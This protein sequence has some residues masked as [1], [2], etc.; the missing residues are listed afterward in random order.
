MKLKLTYVNRVERTSKAGKPFT[1]LS[2]KAEE[3]N[4][5]YLSGFGNKANESWKVGDVVEVDKVVE[6]VK[7]G[8]TYLNFEIAKPEDKVAKYFE[9]I[10]GKL[11]RQ[12]L[13]LEELVA[14]K[15]LQTGEEKPKIAGTNIDY[16]MPEDEG[17]NLEDEEIKY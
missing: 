2:I 4:D 10:L 11:T 1:S 12:N 9:Q 3:Y 5:K 16:P 13:L 8:K 15:R 17:I 7:E 6:V 14:Y